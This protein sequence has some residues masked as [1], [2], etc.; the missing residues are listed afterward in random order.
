MSM[1]D[2]RGEPVHLLGSPK[3]SSHA[4]KEPFCVSLFE[5]CVD[6]KLTQPDDTIKVPGM[7]VTVIF[8]A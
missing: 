4:Y 1:V 2:G 8:I 5:D 6:C 3:P 7:S